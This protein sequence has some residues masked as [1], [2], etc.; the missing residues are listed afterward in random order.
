MNAGGVPRP[1]VLEPNRSA[2]PTDGARASEPPEGPRG[3]PVAAA[4]RRFVRVEQQELRE[5]VSA[6]QSLRSQR[7]ADAEALAAFKEALRGCAS[8]AMQEA[9]RSKPIRAMVTQ[10]QAKALL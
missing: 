6:L 3:A 10:L 2:Q 9:P 4:A 1:R 5:L 7:A 8:L